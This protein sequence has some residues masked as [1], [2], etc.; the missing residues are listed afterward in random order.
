M[1]RFIWN[2][3]LAAQALKMY[4]ANDKRNT[5]I[6]DIAATLGTTV[7]GVCGKLAIMGEYVKVTAAV[8]KK[9]SAPK[10]LTK[11]M[12]LTQVELALNITPGEL[13]GLERASVAGVHALWAAI[14]AVPVYAS[15][16]T[17]AP[18]AVAP[19]AFIFTAEEWDGLPFQKGLVYDPSI[20]CP[21][22]SPCFSRDV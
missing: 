20:V 19:P 17:V 8:P 12:I 6:A 21:V 1:T 7:A 9:A 18:V 5:C 15:R 4:I 10:K 3:E 14:Q 16:I 2:S 11:G 22:L 13:S